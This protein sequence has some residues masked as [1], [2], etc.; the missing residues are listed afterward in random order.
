MSAYECTIAYAPETGEAGVQELLERARQIIAKNGGEPRETHEWGVRELAYP[1]R[2]EKRGLFYVLEFEGGGE[3]VSE[4]ERNLRIAD[5]V[6]RY[7]TVKVDPNRP[8]LDLSKPRREGAEEG[9]EEAPA[10]APA[11]AP[12]PVAENVAEAQPE[13]AE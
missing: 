8:P 5:P 12:A 9:G 7:I 3:A 10:A 6:L 11:P 13:S 2:K 4:L 1:I